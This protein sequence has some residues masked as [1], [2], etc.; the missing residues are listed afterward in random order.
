VGG[1]PSIKILAPPPVVAA[2]LE[3]VENDRQQIA[4]DDLAVVGDIA[5]FQAVE[6]D[7]PDVERIA[8]QCARDV[9]EDGFDHHHP[10]GSAEAAERRVGHGMCLAAVRDDLDVL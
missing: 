10:L 5:L 9:I 2:A 4:L 3:P 8:M 1:V 6:I 7:A